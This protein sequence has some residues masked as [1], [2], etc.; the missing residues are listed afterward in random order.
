MYL[1]PID[2]L[3]GTKPES[4]VWIARK[5]SPSKKLSETKVPYLSSWF[6]PKHEV[7]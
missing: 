1:N 5:A 6:A 4:R 7:H 3:V 2:S